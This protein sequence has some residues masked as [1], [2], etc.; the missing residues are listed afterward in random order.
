MSKAMLIDQIK[1]IGCSACTVACKNIYDHTPFGITRTSMKKYEQGSY[2]D[3]SFRFRKVM[4]VH[5]QNGAPCMDPCPVDAISYKNGDEEGLVLI[6]E[7]TCIGCGVCVGECP[8]GAPQ[9]DE[10]RGKAEKCTFCD[11]QIVPGEPPYCADACPV[12][13]ITFGDREEVIASGEERVEKLQEAGRDQA[14]L[15]GTEDA[16]VFYLLDAPPNTYDLPDEGYTLASLGWR[17]L[18][19]PAGGLITLAAIG[20]MGLTRLRNRMEEV[21]KEEKK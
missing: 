14:S 3:A 19:S 11:D 20:N 7:E 8:F 13:A 15:Y 21:E 2:P 4:C 1:C 12:G 10:E 16:R 5:C 9:M 6:D 17:T 18:T